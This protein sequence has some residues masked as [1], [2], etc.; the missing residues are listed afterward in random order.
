MLT[1]SKEELKDAREVGLG[2]LDN[3]LAVP[4]VPGALAVSCFTTGDAVTHTKTKI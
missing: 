2:H 3:A 4:L 1:G